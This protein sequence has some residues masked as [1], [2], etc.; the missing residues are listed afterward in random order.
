MARRTKMRSFGAG[1]RIGH[2]SSDFYNRKMYDTMDD[3]DTAA[4]EN[5]VPPEHINRVFAHSSEQ[6]DELPDNS[7]HLVI[8]SP[9]Y[10]AGKDF[11]DNLTLDDYLSLL[12]RVWEE[13]YR[14]LVD[15]GRI[16]INIA[17]LG[18]KP[19]LPLHLFIAMDM[20]DIGYMMRGE[21]IWDKGASA[22]N[23]AAWGTWLSA[24]NVVLRDVHEY[25]MVFC[26]DRF[27]RSKGESTIGRAEFLDCTKSVWRM[28]TA[29]AQR[30]G[31][32]TPFP[33]QLPTRL[34]NMYSFK[35][36]VILDPFIG[37]GTTAI[38]AKQLGRNYV[39]YDI[40][41]EYVDMANEQLRQ[42]VLP[43]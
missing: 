14:V 8:T 30:T 22:G 2:D 43:I 38:A 37:S 33:T 41:A 26:K 12:K 34:I 9:P 31:H 19:Y 42:E 36:D 29:S 10:N 20:L 39:G 17:N 35:D 11:D 25:I 15:G 4:V 6:M 7:V 5:A 27:V 40:S 3:P 21:I 16:C 13:S 24:E 23:S 32:P 28:P 1:A 18:R